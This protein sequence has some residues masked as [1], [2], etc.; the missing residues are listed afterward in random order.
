[1][2]GNGSLPRLVQMLL[3]KLVCGSVSKLKPTVGVLRDQGFLQGFGIDFGDPNKW[4]DETDL[5]IV[6]NDTRNEEGGRRAMENLLAKDPGSMWYTP[7]TNPQ[8]QG[9]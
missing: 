7:L 3:L 9:L 6:G 1:M 2:I 4:G 5:R 8:L